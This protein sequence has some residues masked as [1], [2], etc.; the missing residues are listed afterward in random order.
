MQ[1]S[2]PLIAVK[3][4]VSAH[5][6][7]G[8]PG[9]GD[10]AG[11]GAVSGAGI[12]LS[13]PADTRV[14]A[15]KTP[16]RWMLTAARDCMARLLSPLWSSREVALKGIAQVGARSGQAGRGTLAVDTRGPYPVIPDWDMASTR[17]VTALLTDWSRGD[18]TALDR[19]LPLVYAELRRIA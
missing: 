16:A 13:Q 15:S 2:G 18:T 9:A 19:L 6:S 8:G 14:T 10:G 11:V 4:V 5:A 17:S 1:T 3:V 12:E 7:P